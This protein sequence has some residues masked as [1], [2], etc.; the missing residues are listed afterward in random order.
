M[1]I[2]YLIQHRKIWHADTLHSCDSRRPATA[3]P[4]FQGSALNVDQVD[5]A[6]KT[7]PILS[8]RPNSART[9]THKRRWVKR[10]I[11]CCK[12][13][14]NVTPITNDI[15]VVNLS[16][17][18]LSEPEVSV[19]SRR[20]KFVSTSTAVD[21]LELHADLDKFTWRLRLNVHLHKDNNEDD[22]HSLT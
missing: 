18:I 20:A 1:P 11:H 3:I 6:V 19:L 14:C 4:T 7:W 10:P 22:T 9:R 15:S 8:G 5:A 21:D 2:P 17:H 13:R 16:S 12:Q